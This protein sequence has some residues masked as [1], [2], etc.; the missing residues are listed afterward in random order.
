MSHLQETLSQY[1]QNIQVFLFPYLEEELGPLTVKQQQLATLLEVARSSKVK[2]KNEKQKNR[3][4]WNVSRNK[5]LTSLYGW[6]NRQLP[7]NSLTNN[8]LLGEG[9]GSHAPDPATCQSFMQI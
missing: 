3:R 9:R 8:R 4:V 1:W 7:L 6:S 5:P 2:E